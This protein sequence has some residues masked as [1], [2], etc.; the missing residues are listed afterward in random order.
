MGWSD[1]GPSPEN[2]VLKEPK[3]CPVCGQPSQVGIMVGAQLRERFEMRTP[4][5][6][7]L[8]P[9]HETLHQD[10]F[11]ALV[12]AS[13]HAFLPNGNVEAAAAH[14]TGLICHL[15]REVAVELFGLGVAI[16]FPL[17]FVEP[18]V[19][20]DVNSRIHDLGARQANQKILN[21]AEKKHG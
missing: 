19:I 10:G 1:D 20:Q 15:R 5:E 13:K 3:L 18:G 14:R 9:P 16:D 7:G 11:L 6:W 8:C 21:Q 2:H 4:T 12:E 17:I